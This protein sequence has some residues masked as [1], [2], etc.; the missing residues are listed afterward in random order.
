M[1]VHTSHIPFCTFL[2]L[3]PAPDASSLLLCILPHCSAITL[4]RTPFS[5]SHFYIRFTLSH[6][7]SHESNLSCSSLCVYDLT[8]FRYKV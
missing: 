6:L 8:L 4:V 2:L 3:Y 5:V 1:L 7:G